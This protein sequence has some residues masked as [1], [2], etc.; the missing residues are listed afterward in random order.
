[1]WRGSPPT[2]RSLPPPP[3]TAATDILLVHRPGS[4]QANIVLGNT[5]ILA[6]DPGYYP[7]RIA[8]QVLGGGADSRLFLILREQKGWTYGAYANLRRHRGPGYWQATAE[9]RT[10]VADSALS[11]L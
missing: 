5:T 10:E 9:V 7:G 1:D 11:E 6:T 8:T 3:A 2:G 4:T